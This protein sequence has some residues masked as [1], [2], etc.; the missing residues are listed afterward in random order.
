MSD[1]FDETISRQSPST[2][3]ARIA[4]VIKAEPRFECF[5]KAA[6]ATRLLRLDQKLADGVPMSPKKM[7][8]ILNVK[9]ELLQEF[10]GQLA[11]PGDETVVLFTDGRAVEIPVF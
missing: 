8:N 1:N 7:S 10:C 3:A 5:G 4:A 9:P 6:F 2:D 11:K